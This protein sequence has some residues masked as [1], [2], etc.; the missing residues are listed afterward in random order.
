MYKPQETG[1][2]CVNIMSASA[3][4]NLNN[5]EENRTSSACSCIWSMSPIELCTSED[6]ALGAVALEY[7]DVTVVRVTE[8]MGL[9]ETEATLL[10]L[11][12]KKPG[13]N[14]H[15]SLP[16]TAWSAWRIINLANGTPEF[17]EQ[18]G[19]KRYESRKLIAAAIRLMDAALDAGGHVS[20]E[21]PLTC[22]GWHLKEL[23]TFFQKRQI[24]GCRV[25]GCALGFTTSTGEPILKPLW[26]ASSN[27]RL[28]AAL[29]IYR[30]RHPADFVHGRVE[31]RACLRRFLAFWRLMAF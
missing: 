9:L 8:D 24:K 10:Q 1:Q 26:I 31:G 2:N 23:T 21:W 27:A 29:S 12:S 6:S 30:C 15:C 16:C 7:D 25:D 19:A 4:A 18:L 13:V 20:Y 5:G 11:I 28:I 22:T 3:D 17:A 14:I